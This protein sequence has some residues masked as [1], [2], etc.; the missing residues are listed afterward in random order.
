MKDLLKPCL[1]VVHGTRRSKRGMSIYDVD[2][3]LQYTSYKCY[4][5][6]CI[7]PPDPD[8][9]PPKNQRPADFV[10]WHDIALWNMS[11]DGYISNSLGSYGVPIDM[12]NVRIEF[13]KYKYMGFL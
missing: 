5:T 12:D 9:L 3:P 13:G 10:Y 4:Y 8:T 1:F 11:A 6:D 2:R 7:P